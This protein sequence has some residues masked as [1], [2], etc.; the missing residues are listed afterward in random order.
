MTKFREL[1]DYCQTLKPKVSRKDLTPKVCEL[2]G[3]TVKVI[4]SGLDI[5][6]CRGLFLSISN[7][8]NPFVKQLGNNVIVL[9]RD[10]NYCW[11][12][13]VYTKELMHLFDGPEEV[14][15]T[16]EKVEKLFTEFGQPALDR[17]AQISSEVKAF[18]MALACLC[19]EQ[20]RRDFKTQIDKGHTDHLAVALQLR[21]PQQYVGSLFDARYSM[22]IDT[23]LRG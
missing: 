16:K 2:T 10:L 23:I 12:R 7:S 8:E 15:D 4:K 20:F 6:R 19:P 1:Y 22:M 14:T 21:I 11:E 5:T 17:S 9:A 3:S 13:F 18:W